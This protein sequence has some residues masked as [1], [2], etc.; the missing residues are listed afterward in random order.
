VS[1]LAPSRRAL[2][3]EALRAALALVAVVLCAAALLS[4][5]DGVPAWIAGEPRDLRRARTIE[6]AERHLRARLLLPAFFPSAL[7]WPPREV[8][9]V[10]GPPGAAALAVF[11]QDGAPRLVLAQTVGPGEL[12][13]A[14]L[15]EVEVL[16]RTPVAMG[17]AEGT[18]SRVVEDGAVGWQLAWTQDGRSLLWRSR[19]TLDELLRMARSARVPR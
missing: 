13:R 16:D 9:W 2:L 7:A 19:G 17:A 15:P 8:R 6:E 4:A 3:A 12:P 18:L 10:S 5:L 1:A 11:G 14:L